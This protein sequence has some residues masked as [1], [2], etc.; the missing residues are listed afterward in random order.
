MTITGYTPCSGSI[1]A[2]IRTG[3]HIEVCLRPEIED[4]PWCGIVRD[5]SGREI[6]ICAAATAH[7]AFYDAVEG[8]KAIRGGILKLMARNN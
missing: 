1:T 8:A 3:F 5:R 2:P 7:Q 4:G 6:Y